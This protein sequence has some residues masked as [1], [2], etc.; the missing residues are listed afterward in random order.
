MD[1]LK[2]GLTHTQRDEEIDRDR[3]KS[4]RMTKSNYLCI[5]NGN[6]SELSFRFFPSIRIVVISLHCSRW[7][8]LFWVSWKKPLLP[9]CNS[10]ST[11]PI[12]MIEKIV[13]ICML[14]SNGNG[15][16]RFY[17]RTIGQTREF[18]DFILC[19]P[20]NYFITLRVLHATKL[21]I[22]YL[23]FFGFNSSKKLIEKNVQSKKKVQN[24]FGKM[25]LTFN[26]ARCLWNYNISFIYSLFDLLDR[27]YIVYKFKKTMKQRKTL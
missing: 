25:V 17:R 6:L 18:D 14:A 24:V 22:Y 21:E 23:L 19:K 7:W 10:N 26:F 8:C 11:H 1:C 3:E 9:P 15:F 20:H 4:I 16:M 12:K 13:L 5:V 2:I 27:I